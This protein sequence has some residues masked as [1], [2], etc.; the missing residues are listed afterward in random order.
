MQA[1][2]RSSLRGLTRMFGVSRITVSTWIKKS[3]SASPPSA[4][5][6]SSP[7]QEMPLPPRWNSM[8]CGRLCSKKSTRSGCGLP[9]VSQD[10]SSGCLCAG[11]SEQ[12]DMPTFVGSHP[13]SLS[14]GTL[15]YRLLGGIHGGDPR[16]AAHSLGQRDGRNRPC[17]ALEQYPPSTLGSLCPHD[18]VFF[19]VGDHARGVFA[20]LSSPL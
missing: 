4:R 10:A 13:I 12:T 2:E 18:L 6:W 1:Q 7:I 15:L 19:K 3:S 14:P 20:P 8:S 11:G 5:P 9:S 17:G 16:R